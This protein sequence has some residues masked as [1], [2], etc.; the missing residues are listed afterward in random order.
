MFVL[1]AVVAL[2]RDQQDQFAISKISQISVV[3]N[4]NHWAYGFAYALAIYVAFATTAQS[5][6]K[7]LILFIINVCNIINCKARNIA[8]SLRHLPLQLQTQAL[9]QYNIIKL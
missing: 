5:N 1:I 4:R 7:K 3:C 9:G 6:Y 2:K 8:F